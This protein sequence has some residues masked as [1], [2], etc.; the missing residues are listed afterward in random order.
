MLLTSQSHIGSAVYI[1]DSVWVPTVVES[2]PVQDYGYQEN[3]CNESAAQC[4][5]YHVHF[6]DACTHVHWAQLQH[7]RVL[8]QHDMQQLPEPV[9]ES[10][11][12][13]DCSKLLAGDEGEIQW[14][15]HMDKTWKNTI[16]DD[17]MSDGENL[18]LF[19]AESF[20]QE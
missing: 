7:D 1:P 8:L 11:M 13:I 14:V 2:I 4:D 10:S 9:L 12:P 18:K 5:C 3:H 15:N 6:T 19:L 20:S 16:S 17:H